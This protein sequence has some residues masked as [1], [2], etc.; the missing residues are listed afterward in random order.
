M[1]RPVSRVIVFF[2]VF[3]SLMFLSRW[4]SSLFEPS[5]E[6]NSQQFYQLLKSKSI[7]SELEIKDGKYI[8]G[9]Y[10]VI[11]PIGENKSSAIEQ[12]I[13]FTYTNNLAHDL[14][15]L[16]ELRDS[17]VSYLITS[18]VNVFG[19]ISMLSSI[20][21]IF[22]MFK[23]LSPQMKGGSTLPVKSSLFTIINPQQIETTFADIAG[24][25]E[26]KMEL[27]EIVDMV[28]YPQKYAYLNAKLP[29]G[30]LLV[31]PPGTGKTLMAKAV[32]KEAGVPFIATSGSSF[33]EMYVGVGAAR[34]R[35]LIQLAKKNAPCVVF[36][37]EIDS[38]GGKRDGNNGSGGHSEKEQ[39]LNQ[40]L[41]EMDG[42]HSSH[43]I[44]FLA[45]TNREDMLDDALKRAGRFDRKIHVNPPSMTGRKS[46]FHV[47]LSKLKRLSEDT[48][49]DD[50]CSVL[51]KGTPGFTGADIANLV[52]EA[53]LCAARRGS[54]HI[55]QQDFDTAKE[56]ILMGPENRSLI[57]SKDEKMKTSF[58]EVGHT[59]ISELSETLDPIHKVTIIP[60]A[61]SLGV[62]MSLPSDDRVTFSKEKGIETIAMLMG[63]RVAEEI[64]FNGHQSTGASNDIERATSIARNMVY[65]WGMSSLGP[66]NL[67]DNHN[68]KHN[69]SEKTR[70]KADNLVMEFIDQG[71]KLAKE[72]L[73]REEVLVKKMA[74]VLYEKETLDS[75]D[76]KEIIDDYKVRVNS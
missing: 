35:E 38:V 49:I 57:M 47:Y 43:G 11:L 56:K 73:K 1:K 44:F 37:D 4:V 13:P 54:Q 10:K 6:L 21:V 69:F 46:I 3:I 22:F 50:L 60:R 9:E 23:L 17:G 5:K 74:E 15:F 71:Y 33:M 72:I 76:I 39:T 75:N 70:E 62:T 40:L 29:K 59:L 26:I 58:H 20:V 16:K 52:N 65:N 41:V 25:N 48:H 61:R 66:I 7:V 64:F 45:A 53:T 32:A 42:M 51:A 27:E 36:I 19:L 12:K 8:S 18:S 34:V 63:G 14:T 30:A 55:F 24:I 31:G 28:Q 67:S 68:F 2:F